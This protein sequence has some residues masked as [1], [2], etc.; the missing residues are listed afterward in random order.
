MMKKSIFGLRVSAL[1]ET[2]GFLVA[3]FFI[4]MFFGNGDRFI[5][6]NPHPAWII[7]LLVLF[8]Y[9]IRE[10][11]V[12]IIMMCIFL[13]A[14]NFPQQLATETLFQ[15][16]FHLALNPVMWIGMTILLGG[17]RIRTAAR[18]LEVQREL[19]K[20]RQQERVISES[21][22]KLKAA[23]KALEF[24][25]S[26][27][28]G[29][30]IK[31]YRAAIT[32]EDLEGE[33]QMDAVNKIVAS[34]LNPEKFSIFLTTEEGFT[35]RSSYAW[36]QND[37]YSKRFAKNSAIYKSIAVE[38]KVLAIF[39]DNAEKIL[40]NE[41]ILAGPLI[42][43]STG[44]VFGMLKIESLRYQ[45]I[46]LRTMQLFR[47]LCEW[48]GLT[49]KKMQNVEKLASEAITSSQNQRSYSYA[50]LQAQTEFLDALARRIGFHLTKLNI[51]MVNSAELNAEERRL[52]AL[53]MS[54]AIKAALRK[55]DLLFDA[56]ERGEEY[57]LL[58]CGT[59]EDN[60]G[61]VIKKIQDNIAKGD[62][63]GL[64]AKYAFTSQALFVSDRNPTWQGPGS[65]A[66][67]KTAEQNP[68][69]QPGVQK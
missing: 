46:N 10:A 40:R 27:E 62:P 51:R 26:E 23:N 56:R 33:N 36:E 53:A 41:G 52:A 64:K 43:T 28:L 32:L 35:L 47:L 55:T 22:E 7:L 54:I 16:Y 24:K 59:G 61:I 42:N 21:F 19:K 20:A 63:S 29:S 5:N 65:T 48:T 25:L 18:Q 13:Y 37:K 12:C 31:I 8:Q 44:E 57:A 14:G 50:F 34:I 9:A 60:V 17:L 69:A 49:M 67:I 4:D 38:K 45:T 11:A 39:N 2:S 3:L 58:L 66:Q 68:T 6:V 15:Y 30:A 1:M